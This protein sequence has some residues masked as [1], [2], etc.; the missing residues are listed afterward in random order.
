M[1]ARAELEAVRD[2]VFTR[3][4]RWQ[5]GEI[6]WLLWQTGERDVPTDN[7]AEPY[8]LMIAGD[9]A[10]A[11]TVWQKLGCPY[12]EAS[13]L[14]E[15]DDPGMVRQAIAT[16]ERLGARPALMQAMRRLHT[17]G[18]HDL[19]PLRRGPRATTRAHPAGLTQREA[20]VLALVAE[21]CATPRSPSGSS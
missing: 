20:E 8:A 12:E 13:A 19:P 17:L 16:F 1:R 21:D 7:L 18:V 14:A 5:R 10:G 3:G 4:N 11:A 15:S 6:A 9:Y 2:L